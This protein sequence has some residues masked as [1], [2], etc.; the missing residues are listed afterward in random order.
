MIYCKAIPCI[1]DGSRRDRFNKMLFSFYNYGYQLSTVKPRSRRFFSSNIMRCWKYYWS[2]LNIRSCK[3]YWR[4]CERTLM[5]FQTRNSI[6]EQRYFEQ[7]HYTFVWS[8]FYRL[9]HSLYYHILHRLILNYYSFW[10]DV[11]F[12]SKS[13][14]VHSN[15]LIFVLKYLQ[16]GIWVGLS[17]FL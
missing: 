16:R 11:F 15:P 5:K 7:N 17:E 3:T 12:P 2:W 13:I 10:E 8:I 4:S 6:L 14:F 9:F 1:D